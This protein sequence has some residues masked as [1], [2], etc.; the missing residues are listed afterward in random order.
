[1]K[2]KMKIPMK[3]MKIM[4]KK[5]IKKKEFIKIYFFYLGLN[6]IIY[7]IAE[8]NYVFG[9]IFLKIIYE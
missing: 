2:K 1:M 7:I 4:M 3:I 8:R 9:K 5:T 6:I